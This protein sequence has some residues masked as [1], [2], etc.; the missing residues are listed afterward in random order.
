M[1]TRAGLSGSN[2]R[3]L[4]TVLVLLLV[5]GLYGYKIT[6]LERLASQFEDY[7]YAVTNR[8]SARLPRDDV[9]I[10]AIEEQSINKL[11]RWPW[12]RQ[13]LAALLG[14]LNQAQLVALD[15]VFSE[16]S[17]A[18]EDQSLTRQ[19]RLNGN[20]IL[21]NFLRQEATQSTTDAVLEQLDECAFHDFDVRDATIGVKDFPYAETNLL[22]FSR[23]AMSCGVFT[24]EP[25]P[26][27]LFRH[28][29]LAYIHKGLLLPSLSVQMLRFA[30]NDAGKL[31]LDKAGIAEFSMADLTI[32]D[33]NYFRINFYDDND[34]SQVSALSVLQGDVQ[35]A[36]FAGKKVIL[37][38]TEIGVYDLRPTPVNVVT[39]GVQIHYTALNNLLQGD[40]YRRSDLANLG[41]LLLALSAVAGFSKLQRIRWR[42]IGYLGIV[43]GVPAL[44]VLFAVITYTWL[45]DFYILLGTLLLILSLEGLAYIR[46]D[47]QARQIRRAFASYVSPEV[48]N[49]ILA[50]PAAMQLGGKERVVTVMFADIRNFTAISETMNPQSLV[51]MLNQ[52]FTK[53]TNIVLEEHGLLDKYIGDAMMVIF[54]APVLLKDHARHACLSALRMKAGLDGINQYLASQQMPSIR[55]GVG[56]NTGVAV[57]GNM[58]SDVRFSYTAIGDSVNLSSRLE[59]LSKYFHA[60]VVVSE[61]T[62]QSVADKQGLLFRPLDRIRVKG[63]VEPI[64][65]Y[66]L[67]ED[68]PHNQK[69]ASRFATALVCCDERDFVGAL[70]VFTEIVERQGDTVSAMYAE[71][72]REYIAR[73][74]AADWD[75]VFTMQGK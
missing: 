30:S 74:P 47:R 41:I 44:S 54:N 8:F 1:Q 75:G 49:E 13:Q 48:V 16:P 22:Q 42:G 29:P 2:S 56:I 60:P 64:C 24:V 14:K 67:L 61:Q 57:V 63:R 17:N 43:G 51:V 46:S 70:A 18:A 3:W 62:M 66:E 71:R 34:I 39:P 40:Y 37:G 27:G 26:D 28:Y 72:M 73:P 68:S 9:V 55:I 25:D 31:T 38:I 32:L 69:I 10:V 53:L 21:G 65:I 58:G 20:V 19:I 45:S 15:I 52:V 4:L 36:W 50:D 5:G 23:A 11:G 35:P 7:K 12:S 33:S 6:L 59:G